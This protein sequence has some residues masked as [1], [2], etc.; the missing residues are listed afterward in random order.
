MSAKKKIQLV[1]DEQA[2]ATL[3]DLVEATKAES[4]AHVLRDALG[5]YSTLHQMLTESPSSQ[6]ALID[7][8]K[9]E[10]QE[11]NIPSLQRK[12]IVASA[13]APLSPATASAP[14]QVASEQRVGA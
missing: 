5:V 3:E 10:L 13:R 11:L 1:L 9:Q 4:M 14:R 7:R 2:Q 6:L 12:A 8:L